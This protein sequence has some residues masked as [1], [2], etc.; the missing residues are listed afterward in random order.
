MN[1]I[2]HNQLFGMD[3]KGRKNQHSG[4]CFQAH[5]EELIIGAIVK[6]AA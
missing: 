5:K 3:L 2:K 4:L 1:A 6:T